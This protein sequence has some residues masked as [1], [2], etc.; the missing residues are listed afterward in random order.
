M[1]QKHTSPDP[2]ETARRASGPCDLEFAQPTKADAGDLPEILA[3]IRLHKLRIAGLETAERTK[4]RAASEAGAYLGAE[5][6]AKI[7]Q[8]VSRN[9]R[10][11]LSELQPT[12][13][14][15]LGRRAADRL[16]SR[17]TKGSIVRI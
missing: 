17:I 7:L 15:F 5:A 10:N 14:L 13:S 3:A 16:S 1:K 9:C 12:L 6:T 8:R 11:L 2:N 4:S